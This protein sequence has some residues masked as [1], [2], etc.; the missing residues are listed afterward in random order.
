MCLNNNSWNP[1]FK[2][3]DLN[4]LG[5]RQNVFFFYI[6]IYHQLLGANYF[7]KKAPS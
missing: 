2:K 7:L 6:Q 4:L 5:L 3:S 1:E